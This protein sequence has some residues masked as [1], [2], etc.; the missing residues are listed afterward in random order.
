MYSKPDSPFFNN[1]ISCR[2]SLW[3]LTLVTVIRYI[4]VMFPLKL[5]LIVTKRRVKIV[6]LSIWLVIFVLPL[7]PFTLNSWY[8]YSPYLSIC[9]W[10]VAYDQIQS[11]QVRFTF[12]FDNFLLL[13]LTLLAVHFYFNFFNNSACYQ[14]VKR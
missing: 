6:A 4:S 8:T 14:Q 5:P 12:I 7:V 3:F 9:I 2:T 1:P 11:F 13:T 10:H